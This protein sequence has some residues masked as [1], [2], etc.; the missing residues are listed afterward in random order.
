MTFRKVSD[1]AF[2]GHI[3]NPTMELHSCGHSHNSPGTET[4]LALSQR[5]MT[6]SFAKIV[7]SCY[8]LLFGRVFNTPLQ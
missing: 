4:Y 6:I 3:K 5:F 1:I 2:F 8:H 7:N